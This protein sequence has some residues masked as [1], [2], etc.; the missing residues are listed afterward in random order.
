M[1]APDPLPREALQ[2][3]ERNVAALLFVTVSLFMEL[4]VG[5]LTSVG[6]FSWQYFVYIALAVGI[7]LLHA[8]EVIR[9]L[10]ERGRL[11][12]LLLL[13]GGGWQLYMGD[14]AAAAQL[15]LLVLVAGWIST[16]RVKLDVRDLIELYILLIVAGAAI[17]LLTDWNLYSLIPGRANPDFG[18]WRV[19]FY[20]NVAYSGIVSLAL[21][22]IL[23]SDARIARAYPLVLAVAAYFLVFSFVRGALVSLLLYVLLRWWFSRWPTP[24]PRRMFWTALLAAFGF[25]M[26]MAVSARVIYEIQDY[27]GISA[28][29]LRGET[30]VSLDRISYQLY[31]PWLWNEQIK[32]FFSSPLLG[33]WGSADFYGLVAKTIEIPETMLISAGTEALPT[34]LLVVFGLS[35]ALFTI[36][37]IARLRHLAFKDDRWACACFPAL[38]SLM[39]S[40]GS[41]FHASDGMFV[42][43]LLI[44][45]KGADGF[46][47]RGVPLARTMEAGAS[48]PVMAA[49]R[50]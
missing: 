18:V 15:L 4:Q 30:G 1:S 28:L 23:T 45:T 21:L 14:T 24:R 25:V 26:A 42:I 43:L 37:L 19:S 11:L 49:Q 27:P 10:F 6:R 44:M 13:W 41:V 38:F 5:Q 31:R 47:R 35:G 34:R 46:T 2:R 48:H 32:L 36:Y 50:G 39:M 16:D 29:L 22:L 40:W 33:G 8:P 3:S 20:P 9:A 7:P 17:L 12:L